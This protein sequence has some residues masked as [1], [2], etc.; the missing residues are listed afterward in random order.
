[1]AEM[2]DLQENAIIKR[3]LIFL[4]PGFILGFMGFFLPF[5]YSILPVHEADICL[6]A[7]YSNKVAGKNSYVALTNDDFLF[8]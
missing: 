4:T 7:F 8:L 2:A 6:C 1:L 3:V 5:F